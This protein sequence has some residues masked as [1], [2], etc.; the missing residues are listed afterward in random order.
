MY[1]YDCVEEM[2][3][4]PNLGQYRTYGLVGY[5]SSEGAAPKRAGFVSDVSVDKAFVQ[6]LAKAMN[7]G[8]A[9]PC[10]M[11]DMVEDALCGEP[12]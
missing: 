4:D 12:L 10:H 9:H 5:K 1:Y 3:Y 8:Q 6:Q 2:K 7:E 11:L